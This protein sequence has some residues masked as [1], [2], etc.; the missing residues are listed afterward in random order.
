[1]DYRRDI[2]HISVPQNITLFHCIDSN[3]Q[4]EPSKQDV[5]TTL[6]WLEHI[7]A[8]KDGKL[9]QPKSKSLLSQ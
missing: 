1:M 9:T 3:I 5:A 4:I 6:D 7:C 8:L 2:G